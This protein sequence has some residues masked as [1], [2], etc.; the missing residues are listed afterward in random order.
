MGRFFLSMKLF[1]LLFLLSPALGLAQVGSSCQDR[2]NGKYQCLN[3]EFAEWDMK[4]SDSLM[5][6]SNSEYGL[7]ITSKI[8]WNTECEFRSTI[9]KVDGP[10]QEHLLDKST[11]VKI[12]RL[13]PKSLGIQTME[14][15]ELRNWNYSRKE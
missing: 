7:I 5:T 9:I 11:E 1:F 14:D 13:N 2:I 12:T 3:E 4:I 15:G 10:N 8:V 6:Q